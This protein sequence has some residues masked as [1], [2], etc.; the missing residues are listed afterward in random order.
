VESVDVPSW[1]FGHFSILRVAK[2]WH[3]KMTSISPSPHWDRSPNPHSGYVIFQSSI[4]SDGTGAWDGWLFFFK[5]TEKSSTHSPSASIKRTI[6]RERLR[7]DDRLTQTRPAY[8]HHHCRNNN[9]L[10][11][12]AHPITG[13]GSCVRYYNRDIESVIA[14]AIIALSSLSPT[15]ALFRAI[16]HQPSKIVHLPPPTPV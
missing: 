13:R 6:G 5:V 9:S 11:S 2:K 3:S 1:I 10:L 12:L 4:Q 16:P 14:A 15:I 8:H 7:G